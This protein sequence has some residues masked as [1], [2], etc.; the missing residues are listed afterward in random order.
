M[1]PARESNAPEQPYVVLGPA[2]RPLSGTFANGRI[3]RKSG[4]SVCRLI[5]SVRVTPGLTGATG[6]A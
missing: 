4:S 2:A 3:S 1:I 5:V 6:T